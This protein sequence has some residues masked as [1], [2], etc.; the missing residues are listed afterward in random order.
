MK[1]TFFVLFFVGLFLSS[2]KM[3][4]SHDPSPHGISAL[5]SANSYV[6]DVKMRGTT[7]KQLV[8]LIA[9]N[10][11]HPDQVYLLENKNNYTD[12]VSLIHATIIYGD[13]S[14][15]IQEANTGKYYRLK[16]EGSITNDGLDR[17]KLLKEYV[18]YGLGDHNNPS[19]YSEA[20][21]APSTFPTTLSL[22]CH[23]YSNGTNMGLCTA[24]GSGSSSC[25]VTG[26]SGGCTVTCS[27][28]NFACC[29]L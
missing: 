28:G 11:E 8:V 6:A 18:G 29:M 12:N 1:K 23:C 24:G 14:L 20:D 3:M 10:A 9:N 2:F 17:K 19:Y 27:A 26:S 21:A 5:Q 4:T 13:S 7:D 16:I 15:I 25:S 22:S